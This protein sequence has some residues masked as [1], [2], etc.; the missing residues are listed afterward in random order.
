MHKGI[1]RDTKGSIYEG[2][3]NNYR[4]HGVGTFRWEDGV[5][6]EGSFKEGRRHGTGTHRLVDGM[7]YEGESWWWDLGTP[8][9]KVHWYRHG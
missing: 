1:F 7:V 2:E 4:P 3:L 8:I 5:V 6:Y 9:Q